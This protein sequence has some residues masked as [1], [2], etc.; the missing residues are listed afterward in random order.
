MQA[1][2]TVTSS[3]GSLNLR[4]LILIALLVAFA[5]L[6]IH[7]IAKHGQDAVIASQC[8]DRPQFQMVRPEDG[9]IASI[10]LTEDGWGVYIT[11]ANG[12][13]VTAFLKNKLDTVNKVI[14]YMQNRGY[15]LIQ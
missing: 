4:R 11:E 9:R 5:V 15:E 1:T 10:C 14:R 13:N 3:G 2:A 6:S 8:G 12:N 7:A